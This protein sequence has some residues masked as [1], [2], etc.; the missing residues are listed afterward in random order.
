MTA[1]EKAISQCRK[2]LAPAWRR[3]WNQEMTRQDRRWFLECARV[4]RVP[5][6]PWDEFTAEQQRAILK[7]YGSF[8]DAMRIGQS[9]E[10]VQPARF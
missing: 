3:Y 5:A 4:D 6:T 2:Q 7:A 9:P 10:S 1:R 8:A